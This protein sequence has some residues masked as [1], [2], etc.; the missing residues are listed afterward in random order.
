MQVLH[1]LKELSEFDRSFGLA[2][3]VFDG[4]HLG[5]QAVIEAARGAGALGVL[6]FDPHPVEVLA[7]KPCAASCPIKPRSKGAYPFRTRGRFFGDHQIF[8]G[9]RG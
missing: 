2:L 4:I 3:G 1:G 5:H 6:T 7:P 8:P 9:I